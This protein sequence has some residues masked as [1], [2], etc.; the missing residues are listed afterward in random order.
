MRA[1]GTAG[2][3]VARRC[4][5]GLCAALAL[6]SVSACGGSSPPA[7][8]ASTASTLHGDVQRIRTAASGHDAGHAHSAVA[9]LRSD[10][11]RLEARGELAASDAHVLLIAAGRVDHRVS[12]EVKAVPPAATPASALAPE[13]TTAASASAVAAPAPGAG[14]GKGKGKGKGDSHGA[15][16]GHGGGDGGD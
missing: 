13:T 14:D 11:A 12:V 7:I 1:G 5:A 8:S 15:G 16:H 2:R 4:V 10:I 3:R 9:A 6:S